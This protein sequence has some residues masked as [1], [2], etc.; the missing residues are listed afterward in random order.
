MLECLIMGDDIAANIARYRNDCVVEA[1]SSIK[2]RDY[3]NGLY[4]FYDVTP[5]KTTVISLGTY[6]IDNS[7]TYPVLLTL[8]EE[9]KGTV[10]WILPARNEEARNVM[11]TIARERGD[12][13]ADTRA[14]PLSING[15]HP[16]AEAYKG[17]AKSF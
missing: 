17:L 9:I 15:V 12:S 10:L 4:F 14:W 2:S 5:A 13:V 1:V 3:V 8:R 16:T 7:E 6:D 11:L